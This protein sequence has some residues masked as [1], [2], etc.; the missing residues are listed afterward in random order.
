[1]FDDLFGM[2]G[3]GRR[4]RNRGEDLRVRIKL[5]LEEIASGVEKSLRVK[6][7]IRCDACN[8]SGVAAGS[9]RK[10]C[11]QCRGSGRVRTM[12]RTILGTI[13]QVTTC[14]MC[15]GT[16][17]VI[18]DPCRTCNGEGRVRGTSTVKV[19]VPPGVSSGNYMTV[20]SMGNA[21]PGNGEPGDVIV[22]FE[23]SEHEF[24]TR[25]GD[26]IICE[27]PI[28][29]TTA[30]MGGI[31]SVPTIKGEAQL[32]IPP[33]TQPG[34]VLKM[35]GKG[36]PHLHQNGVGDQLV[37]ITVWVPTKLS[38]N[39]KAILEKLEGSESFRPPEGGKS[40]FSKLRESF[41]V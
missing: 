7:L 6:R 8:G 35:R 31:V 37:Q 11:P 34:K 39:D 18:S 24:F 13:Q 20:D 26:N 16:G 38:A 10:T 30:A 27:L 25:H 32:R 33:G 17:E 1:M 40:F 23:E 36:I 21:A 15:R 3:G 5:S 28:A 29:F 9:S 2:G 22:V 14:N 19:K 41:G 4:Q 12:S